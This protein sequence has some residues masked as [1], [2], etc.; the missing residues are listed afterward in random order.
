[1]GALDAELRAS[2]ELMKELMHSNWGPRASG[3][4]SAVGRERSDELDAQVAHERERLQRAQ[5]RATE[6]EAEFLHKSRLLVK[7]LNEE[8][9]EI[10]LLVGVRAR[11]AECADEEPLQSVTTAIV[12]L[13]ILH[14]W[15][16]QKIPI[17]IFNIVLD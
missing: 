8:C 6:C 14:F 7:A 4:S 5:T 9:A 11:I 12:L 13:Y 2:Q 10:A 17:S 3:E 15:T 16:R 1:M